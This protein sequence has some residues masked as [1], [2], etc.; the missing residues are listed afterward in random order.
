MGMGSD[1]GLAQLRC[2]VFMI[3]EGP[4]SQRRARSGEVARRGPVSGFVSG[5]GCAAS[6][7]MGID[8]RHA[9]AGLFQLPGEQTACARPGP[10]I[11]VSMG[12]NAVGQTVVCTASGSAIWLTVPRRLSAG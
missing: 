6:P 5:P 11:K 9:L 1:Q 12:L 2:Q 10:T 7:S 4:L 8:D 3:G